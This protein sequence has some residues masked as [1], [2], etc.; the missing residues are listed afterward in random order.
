[1]SV[2][3]HE[4]GTFAHFGVF[5]IFYLTADDVRCVLSGGDDGLALGELLQEQADV[6]RFND[7]QKLVGGILL[8][9][10]HGCGGVIKGDA[11]FGEE[12]D[13][14]FLVESFLPGDEEV[15]LVLEEEEAED[16]PHVVLQVGVEEIHAPTFLLWRETSQHQQSGFCREKGF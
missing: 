5:C 9:P 16:A 13:E 14:S 11:F 4:R 10:A 6:R 1:M 8:Q 7:F 3:E 12:G 15:F 2:L